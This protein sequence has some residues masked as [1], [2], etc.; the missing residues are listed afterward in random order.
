MALRA[1][2]LDAVHQLSRALGAGGC[3][4]LNQ[5]KQFQA[6]Q[7]ALAQQTG[8]VVQLNAQF[9]RQKHVFSSSVSHGTIYFCGEWRLFFVAT[10]G[11]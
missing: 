10:C 9:L 6:I 4:D 8:P 7:V 3:T 2:L 1:V 5:L 11:D